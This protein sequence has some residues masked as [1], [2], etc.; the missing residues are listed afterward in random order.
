MD[1]HEVVNDYDAETVDPARYAAGRRAFLDYYPVRETGL[2]HD[3]SCAGD[4]LYRRFPLGAARSS[5]SC[6]TSARAGARRGAICIGGSRPT[7]PRRCA[8]RSVLLFCAAP[9][10]GCLEAIFDPART[11]LGP[12]QKAQFLSRSR[13]LDREVEAVVSEEPIQQFHALP[14]DRFEGTPRS[15]PSCCVHP[16]ER[17]RG[18][19]VPDH[20]HARDDAQ[21]GRDRRFAAPDSDRVELVTGRSRRTPSRRGDPRRRPSGCRS[22]TSC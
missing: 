11:L 22:S 20:R 12:V 2:P 21:P 9:P 10:P 8:R 5:C 1:D 19:E 14:Y 15:A 4:P 18:R 16:G 7:L 17:D 3:P 6:S 13:R